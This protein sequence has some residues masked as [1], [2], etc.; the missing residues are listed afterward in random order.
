MTIQLWPALTWAAPRI[1]PDPQLTPFIK[2]PG[3]K[4]MELPAIAM[5][6]PAL[7]GRFIDPFVGGGSVLFA[8]PT[9]IAAQVN[10]AS[11]DLI[12]L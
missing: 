4:S 7:T 11:R 3:G 9:D 2:W 12:E 6:A 5:A 10:D 1:S 8:T